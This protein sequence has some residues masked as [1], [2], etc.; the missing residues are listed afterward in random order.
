MGKQ[1]YEGKSETQIQIAFFHW[2]HFL[3]DLHEDIT[4]LIYAVPNGGYRNP[5]EAIRLKLEGVK[6]GIPD[7]NIDI[8]SPRYHGMRIEFKRPDKRNNTSEAQKR[9]HSLLREA[10]YFVVICCSVEEAI[11]SL[12]S[13]VEPSWKTTPSR[14]VQVHTVESSFAVQAVASSGTTLPE[15]IA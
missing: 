8:P 5:K 7:V 10:G 15:S 12:A 14:S 6:P 4:D 3:S 9:K 13:K 1:V 2:V 11:T